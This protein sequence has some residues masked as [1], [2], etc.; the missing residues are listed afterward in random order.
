MK[1]LILTS[2]GAACAFIGLAQS[3]TID[4]IKYV[5]N[6]GTNTV[7]VEGFAASWLAADAVVIP[8]SVEI[9]GE[10]YE[11]TKIA[12]AAFYGTQLKSISLP[13][14]ITSLG[15]YSFSETHLTE[16]TVPS[17]VT[18]L[19]N[20]V[21]AGN[22]YLTHVILNDGLT[23][24]G[25]SAF[26]NCFALEYIDIPE[27]VSFFGVAAFENCTSMEYVNFLGTLLQWYAIDFESPN[28]NPI[29]SAHE[30][31]MKGQTP[32]S[33]MVLPSVSEVKP[34]V[35]VNCSTLVS[36]D[37]MDGVK[38]IGENA[39]SGCSDLTSVT[40][41]NTLESVGQWAFDNCPSLKKV[42]AVSLPNFLNIDFSGWNSNPLSN[43]GDLYVA[44]N[45]R[46]KDPT[47]QL[48]IPDEIT[49]LKPYALNGCAS[50]ESVIL[51]DG[52]TSI[53]ESSFKDCTALKDITLSSALTSIGKEAFSNCTSL[54]AV[55]MGNTV[56]TIGEQAF[57]DCS[58]L[59]ELI[60]SDNLAEIPDYMCISCTSLPTLSIPDSVKSIGMSA[61]L[62]CEQLTEVNFGVGVENIGRQAF[63]ATGLTSVNI[64]GDALSVI[65]MMAFY[66]CMSLTEVTLG[67]GLTE[68]GD[69]AFSF[70]MALRDFTCYGT[71][72][73]TATNEMCLSTTYANATL[74]VPESAIESYKSASGWSR[75]A[76]IVAIPVT[77]ID[78][79]EAAIH[80]SPVIYYRLDGTRVD[81][82]PT[83]GTYIRLQDTTTTKII[84]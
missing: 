41:Y 32:T 24:I 6:E 62:N 39:F 46:F 28:A 7:Y 81:G 22:D 43:G 2:L 11:V 18:E 31:R 57:R 20:S 21:F 34:N 76:N 73:A 70:C 17:G 56:T 66:D 12:T 38:T 45:G 9:D 61:F 51:H 84:L 68:V 71:Q 79:P 29:Y 72:P 55:E 78:L 58:S 36:V 30:W 59:T 60:L 69:D 75:F 27:T 5:A 23:S 14:T 13:E 8:S 40:F 3:V 80:D 54:E 10:S 67:S 35:F 52:V 65:G 15:K 74:H 25:S 83:S 64:S 63:S 47:T 82:E 77:G 33:I 1:K 48:I 53:G 42:Y 19:P 37:F 44:V 26:M 4:N 49:E 50:I 16:F